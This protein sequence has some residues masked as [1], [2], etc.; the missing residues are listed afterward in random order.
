MPA[1]LA[2]RRRQYEDLGR[3]ECTILQAVAHIGS[4]HRAC[5]MLAG[6]GQHGRRMVFDLG[7][8]RGYVE[9]IPWQLVVIADVALGQVGQADTE[10]GQERK[11]LW[12]Q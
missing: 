8:Q 4:Q 3:T 9:R 2:G 12:R 10:F 11:L 5:A 6:E 7:Q 1:R